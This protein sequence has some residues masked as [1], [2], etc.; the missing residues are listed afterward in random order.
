[1]SETIRHE[2]EKEDETE[3]EGFLR[4]GSECKVDLRNR[5]IVD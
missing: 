5:N 4:K 2:A 3:K 1:M